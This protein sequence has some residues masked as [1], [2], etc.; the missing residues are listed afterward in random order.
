M[1]DNQTTPV[2]VN[3]NSIGAQER[4]NEIRAMQSK[5]PNLVVPTSKGANRKLTTAASVPD[6]F[7]EASIVASV[8]SPEL[9]RG[10]TAAPEEIRDLIT[11][12]KSY[13]MVAAELEGLARFIRH[14]TRIARNEAGSHALTTYALAQRLVKRAETAY[15]APMLDAMTRALNIRKRKAA[16]PA[17]EPAPAPTTQTA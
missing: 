15:I 10:G 14:S 16:K 17:D 7:V 13:E 1:S 6:L 3:A 4:I 5:I 2:V 8:N 12:A 11:Y 9:V